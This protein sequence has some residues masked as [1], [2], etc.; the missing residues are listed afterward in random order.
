MRRN[1]DGIQPGRDE[2]IHR[3]RRAQAEAE[4]RHVQAR[5]TAIATWGMPR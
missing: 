4:Q 2:E 5:Q 3:A 1:S